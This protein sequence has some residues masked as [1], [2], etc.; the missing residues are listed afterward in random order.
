LTFEKNGWTL[1]K[2]KRKQCCVFLFLLVL[3]FFLIFA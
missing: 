3:R 1:S 2:K